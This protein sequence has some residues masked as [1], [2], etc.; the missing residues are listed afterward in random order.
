MRVICK[1]RCRGDGKLYTLVEISGMEGAEPYATSFCG[2]QEVP[3]H[4]IHLSGSQYVLVAVD[5]TRDQRVLFYSDR[6][7][8]LNGEIGAE[9]PINPKRYTF[10]SKANGVLRKELCAQ[11]RNIDSSGSRRELCLTCDGFIQCNEDGKGAFLIRGSVSNSQVLHIDHLVAFDSSGSIISRDSFFL[12]SI[13]ETEGSYSLRRYSIY[14]PI[15]ISA[16]DGLCIAAVDEHGR[17]ANA[18]I[19]YKH[20]AYVW[21]ADR[22]IRFQ[23]HAVDDPSYMDWYTARRLTES[24]AV[25]QKAFTWDNGPLFSVI[26]PLYKTPLPFFRDMA[27]SVVR[28]TY[29]NWELILVNSTP[30]DEAL[31]RLVAE[32]TE[33]DS[34]IRSIDLEGN[35]GITGNTNV[36]IEHA[37]GDFLCFFDHDDIVEPD[38]LFEYAKAISTDDKIDLLYCDEDKLYPNGLF[39]TPV[40]KPDFNIDMIRDN[41]YICHLLTVRKAAYDRIEPSGK[42]LDGAQD[43]AM[44]L[45]I[46]ELGGHIHHVPKVLYHWR[47]SPTSTA[48][49][50]ADN[51]PYATT[52]GILAVQ[53][54]LDRLGIS[55]RVTN[56]HE[57]AFR[58]R[59]D[60]LPGKVAVSLIVQVRNDASA[61]RPLLD[62][63]RG[64]DYAP[65]E[66]VLLCSS[67]QELDVAA[68]VR[69]A[70]LSDTAVVLPQR[71]GYS[72][73]CW[74]NIGARASHGDCLVFMCDDVTPGEPDWLNV[75]VGFAMRKDV[76]VVG[77]MTCN[78]DQ[79]I[80]Q[81]GFSFLR[82]EVIPLSPGVHRSMPGYL[83]Y[84]LTVRDVAAVDDA[85]F[86]TSRSVFDE[87]GGF[88]ESLDISYVSVDYS[89]AVD[90]LGKCVVYTPEA[91]MFHRGADG[92]SLGPS[93]HDGTEAR[94]IQDKAHLLAKWSEKLA[95]DDPCFSPNF[96]RDPSRAMLYKLDHENALSLPR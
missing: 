29:P 10:A 25:E 32:Y 82:D 20:D 45:K 36:G 48:G 39:G 58:Y 21:M 14:V 63:L 81:A 19:S 71:D 92:G 41:N 78:L 8:C 30:E 35:L 18:V 86:A 95:G 37:K 34:R 22:S 88:D 33:S 64:L 38:V 89:F 67:D 5:F 44:V 93:N 46:S 72:F 62:S 69:Q 24:K 70:G 12:D 94:R 9:F 87:V 49:D 55:A 84:P 65:L 31:H 61:L 77:T 60:Y 16:L 13:G 1:G 74:A 91:W 73:S 47:V 79:T 56:A 2:E 68:A 28:Q 26:V 75:L 50:N 52:A 17:Y 59:V 66:L 15:V 54:H 80:R 76:G 3:C 53:Q 27:D 23:R 11:I 40:F 4:L 43:H 57:R 42:E 90:S 83:V 6:T 96:S 51:K 85:C 7:A